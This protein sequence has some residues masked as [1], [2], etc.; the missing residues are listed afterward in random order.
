MENI[1]KAKIIYKY[2]EKPNETLK[3]ERNQFDILMIEKKFI[4]NLNEM[5]KMTFERLI[6]PMK[7]YEILTNLDTKISFLEKL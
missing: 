7:I 2:I 3:L 4:E 1:N 6:K 5:E